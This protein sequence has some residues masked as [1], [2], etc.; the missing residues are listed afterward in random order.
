MNNRRLKNNDH[1]RIAMISQDGEKL[2]MVNANKRLINNENDN[3]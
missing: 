2:K 1:K 3:R